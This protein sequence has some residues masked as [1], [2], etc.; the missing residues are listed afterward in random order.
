MDLNEVVLFFGSQSEM[1]RVLGVS[2]Q[3]VSQWVNRDECIPPK[4]A[5]IVE[6]LTDGQFSAMDFGCGIGELEIVDETL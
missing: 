5:I 4:Q 6:E 3:A 2:R 1:G